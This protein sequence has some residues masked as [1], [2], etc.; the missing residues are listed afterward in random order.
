M[1]HRLSSLG[2]LVLS[3]C[4][5]APD[6]TGTAAAPAPTLAVPSG[7]H[8]SGRVSYPSEYL[9]PMRVCALAAADPGR[10]Y[11]M[12]TAANRP[13]YELHVP[14][15]D[16]WLLAWPQDTGSTGD[17]GLLSAASD[18]LGAGGIDCD[19][20]QLLAVTVSD[21]ERREALDINDWYYDP[22]AFPPP[23]P[24]QDLSPP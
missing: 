2:L 7:A 20:H 11:C 18:C 19:E 13:H 8:L 22:R 12:Q 24:P 15:G 6:A 14:A 10:A 5:P 4:A 21:G 1:R 16:W 3:A 9:P 17:P 23:M